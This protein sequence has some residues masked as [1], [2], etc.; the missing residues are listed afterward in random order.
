MVSVV[1][2]CCHQVEL[3]TPIQMSQ[4]YRQELTCLMGLQVLLEDQVYKDQLHSVL[5]LS[6][7]GV[8]KD[9]ALLPEPR[10]VPESFRGKS[11]AQIQQEDEE[12][13]ERLVHQFRRH[14]FTCYFDTESLAR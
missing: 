6:G 7:E 4:S 5:H 12:K 8:K 2:L 10:H 13:V 3:Q 9:Q 14:T 11:L 1:N